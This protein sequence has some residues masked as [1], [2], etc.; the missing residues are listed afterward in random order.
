MRWIWSLRAVQFVVQYQITVFGAKM[1]QAKAFESRKPGLHTGLFQ[2]F[3]FPLPWVSRSFGS[4]QPYLDYWASTSFLVARFDFCRRTAFGQVRALPGWSNVDIF[5]IPLSFQSEMYVP[6]PR[7]RGEMEPSLLLVV[8]LPSNWPTV[9]R[10]RCGCPPIITLIFSA[11][12][13]ANYWSP[14]VLLSSLLHVTVMCNRKQM[15][16]VSSL[17]RLAC[18]PLFPRVCAVPL[19][20]CGSFMSLVI[21][22]TILLLCVFPFGVPRNLAGLSMT[23]NTLFPYHWDIVEGLR[24]PNELVPYR[25]RTVYGRSLYPNCIYRLSEFCICP[26]CHVCLL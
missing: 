6:V 17:R 1:R 18:W 22:S 26:L 14:L 15:V 25:I 9:R 7:W 24:L 4:V 2:S 5:D 19:K 16:W 10:L 20:T 13:W 12:R 23:C 3:A 11:S 21:K 8:S